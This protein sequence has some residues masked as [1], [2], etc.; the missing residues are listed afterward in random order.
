MGD[1]G[2]TLFGLL[3]FIIWAGISLVVFALV[4]ACRGY[5]PR[6]IALVAVWAVGS[7]GFYLVL[8]LQIIPHYDVDDI[9]SLLLWPLLVLMCANGC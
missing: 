4:Y 6:Y 1:F 7:L 3:L 2:N 9:L 8:G 5:K